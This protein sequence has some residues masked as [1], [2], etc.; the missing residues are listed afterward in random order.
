LLTASALN[1]NNSPFM[2]DPS[3][4]ERGVIVVERRGG[5]AIGKG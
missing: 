3:E 1:N 5:L 4:H 2:F